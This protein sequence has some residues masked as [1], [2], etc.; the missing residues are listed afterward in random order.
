MLDMQVG[1]EPLFRASL[2]WKKESGA[3][4]DLLEE[5]KHQGPYFNGIWGIYGASDFCP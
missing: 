3:V 1:Q 4:P 2:L 5:K